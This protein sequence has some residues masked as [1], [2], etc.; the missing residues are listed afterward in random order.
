MS[1]ASS[2]VSD[3]CECPLS[4]S[5]HSKQWDFNWNLEDLLEQLDLVMCSKLPFAGCYFLSKHRK[6]GGQGLVVFATMVRAVNLE[7]TTPSSSFKP[8]QVAIKFHFN[9]V[10]FTS[11]A[12]LGRMSSLQ[13][14]LPEMIHISTDHCDAIPFLA[15]NGRLFPPFVVLPKGKPLDIFCHQ[16]APDF[17]TCVMVRV[18]KHH[19]FCRF[20]STL[21]A[22]TRT[23]SLTHVPSSECC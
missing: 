23:D 4:E 3:V 1:Q 10:A 5:A 18:P 7:P 2:R 6:V 13:G 20:F 14:C 11:E 19:I 9:S 22:R 16:H 21:S 8:L 12:R 17:P 15:P